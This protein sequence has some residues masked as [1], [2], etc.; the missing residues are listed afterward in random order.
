MCRRR[1]PV[2]PFTYRGVLLEPVVGWTTHH[3]IVE[4]DGRWWL[5]YHDALL[6]GGVTHLRT[7]KVAELHHDAD[8]AIRTIKPYG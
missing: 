8:G 1:Q 5:Y 6:S 2:W 7:V 4:F 3:S